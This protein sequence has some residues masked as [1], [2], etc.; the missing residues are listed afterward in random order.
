M[1]FLLVY[2]LDHFAGFD[3]LPYCDEVDY[4]LV[5]F[6]LQNPSPLDQAVPYPLLQSESQKKS[7]KN[8]KKALFGVTTLARVPI[9]LISC[10]IAHK[11]GHDH[12]FHVD[13]VDKKS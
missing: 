12:D 7:Q 3:C 5:P 13:I 9:Q 8:Q 6:D 10:H 11:S 1:A 4:I 2:D